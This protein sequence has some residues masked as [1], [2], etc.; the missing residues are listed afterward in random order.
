MCLLLKLELTQ[1]FPC[2]GGILFSSAESNAWRYIQY[3]PHC[4]GHHIF[5]IATCSGW[6]GHYPQKMSQI[7]TTCSN[8]LSFRIPTKFSMVWNSCSPEKKLLLREK[9]TQFTSR[10]LNETS[11]CHQTQHWPLIQPR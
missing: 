8:K 1:H 2:L 7:V 10:P 3:S 4:H 11:K 9:F 5:A 6:E